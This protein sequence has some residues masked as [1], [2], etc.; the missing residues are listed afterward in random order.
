MVWGEGLKLSITI[1]ELSKFCGV[2]QLSLGHQIQH[3]YDGKHQDPL[4][5]YYVT[6][7]RWLENIYDI[8]SS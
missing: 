5:T 1:L 7:I 6:T 3:P 2:G 8:N 4:K